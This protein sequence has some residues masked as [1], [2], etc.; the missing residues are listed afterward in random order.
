M[1][2]RDIPKTEQDKVD[3][4]TNNLK[5]ATT[6][7]LNNRYIFI[8]F[9]TEGGEVVKQYKV[10]F[11]NDLTFASLEEIPE[12]PENTGLVEY[13]GWYYKTGTTM[14]Q[15]DAITD[16]VTLHYVAEEKKIVPKS[17]SNVSLDRN[18]LLFKG[19]GVGTT[20][21][22]LLGALDNDLEYIVIKDR[23]GNVV[24]DES[25]IAT[26]MTIELISKTDNTKTNEKITIVVSGDVNGDGVVDETDMD[27]AADKC[28]K[29]TYYT[30]EEKAYFAANDTNDDGVLDVF[31]LFNI[32]KISCED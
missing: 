15:S 31:D 6:E 32:G 23:N 16:D 13:F 4:I 3:E 21:E 22:L 29:N 14:N 8:S 18:K 25:V 10:K 17:G 7:L 2:I 20:V 28:L 19:L 27:E 24:S 9:K 30:D 26:G 12:L 5:D 11:A 1:N